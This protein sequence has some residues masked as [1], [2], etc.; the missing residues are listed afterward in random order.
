MILK[1]AVELLG[2]KLTFEG[3]DFSIGSFGPIQNAGINADPSNCNLFKAL[4]SLSNEQFE[5]KVIGWVGEYFEVK[6]RIRS[7][8]SGSRQS[9]DAKANS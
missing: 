7:S 4:E 3:H 6:V 1:R 9:F 5:T 8:F 2:I